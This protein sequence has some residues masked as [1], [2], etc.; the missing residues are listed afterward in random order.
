L[1]VQCD[2]CLTKFKISDEK[3]RGK[4]VRIR[5]ARCHKPFTVRGEEL[6][7]KEESTNEGQEAVTAALNAVAQNIKVSHKG[8]TPKNAPD[9]PSSDTRSDQADLSLDDA[10]EL[11]KNIEANEPLEDFSTAGG[12]D[13]SIGAALGE[14]QQAEDHSPEDQPSE[15]KDTVSDKG[16]TMKLNSDA[17]SI[18]GEEQEQLETETSPSDELD[19]DFSPD[20][21]RRRR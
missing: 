18:D 10:G 5:C 7:E 11:D 1:I 12:L 4:V 14:D 20:D 16:P 3:I 9:S 19:L 6:K 15:D 21:D 13:F 8:G 2:K 17:V